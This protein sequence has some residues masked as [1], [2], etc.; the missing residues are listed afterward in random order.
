MAG[1][2]VGACVG[3]DDGDQGGV[4]IGGQLLGR[5]GVGKSQ[6]LSTMKLCVRDEGL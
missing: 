2:I 1:T 5:T 3:H 6:N 4:I